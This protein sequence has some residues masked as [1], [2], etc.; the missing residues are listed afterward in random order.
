MNTHH[1][2]NSF[3]ILDYFND[4]V[5]IIT[6][7]GSI[8]YAN[9]TAYDRLGYSKEELLQKNIR[10][11][12]SPNY[13]RLIPER[14]EQFKQRDSLVFES[15][16]VTKDGSI[17]PV[18]VSIH[19]ILYNSTHCIISVV[20]DITSR[21]Q[22]EKELRESEEKWRAITE[23]LTDIVWIVNLQFETIYINK[24][25]E[26]LFGFTVDEYLQRKVQEKYPPEVLQDIY[27]KLIEE[28]ENEKKPGIDKNRTRIVEIQEYKKDGTLAD[29]SVHVKFLR[30]EAGNPNAIIGISR[31]ITEQKKRLKEIQRYKL[32]FEQSINEIYIFDAKTLMF[33]YVNQ[34]SINNLGYSLEELQRMTPVD[35]KP[36]FTLQQFNELLSPL[37]EG[38][39]KSIVFET[40]HK[41]KD[42][43]TYA[44]EVHLQLVTIDGEEHF[45][46]I[47]LD[48]SERKRIEKSL[49]ESEEKFRVLAKSTPMGIMLYQDDKWIYA[50][51]AAEALLKYSEQELCSMNF[52]DVV[53][54]D[55]KTFIIEKGR[56]RQKG[57]VV[58]LVTECRIIDKSGAIKWVLLHG[59]TVIYKGKPAGLISV[60]DVT[61]RKGMEEAL[62]ESEEKFRILAEST[63]MTIMMYQ[64]NKWIYANP[65]AEALLEYSE[66]ELFSMNFWDV[67]HPDDK[68]IVIERGSKRQKGEDA[69]VGY[70]FRVISKS[71]M[72][73]WVLLYGATVMYKGK[74]AGLI[75]VLDITER[76]KIEEEKR[77]LQE[78]L[79]QS[80]KMES[81]GTLAGGVA[82]EFNNMLNIISGHAELALLNIPQ[83]NDAR[84][85]IEEIKKAAERSAEIT[86]KLLKFARKQEEKSSIVNVNSAI[87]SM[88][89]MLK[90]LIG[91]NIQLVWQPANRELSVQI[92]EV[93][94]DQ[95]LV[96]LSVNARD[97]IDKQGTITIST[98]SVSIKDEVALQHN[99]LPGEYALI[100]VTDNGIGIDEETQK[101]IFDP[102]FTTK[103][104]GKGTGLGL[105]TV[106][107]IVK[108]N[109]GFI[110][111][112]SEKGKGTTFKIYLPVFI[113]RRKFAQYHDNAVNDLFH[114]TETILIVEDEVSILKMIKKMLEILGYTVLEAGDPFEALEIVKN[115]I[116]TIHL[117]ITDVVMPKMNGVDLAKLVSAIYPQI[118]I[119][120]TSGYSAEVLL[121]H[122]IKTSDINYLSKPVSFASLASTVR[123]ILDN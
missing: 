79:L 80:Q 70:E 60:M 25:V 109:G 33:T 100:Q 6:Y 39:E 2:E 11:I 102:F 62:K 42:G 44:V 22:A 63:P 91:E 55:D 115:Y 52:W 68:A 32:I 35:I 98:H 14:I 99:V 53:H 57:K 104:V 66:Q 72:I 46:A 3:D 74:P 71:G 95:I 26:K 8:V 10:D 89:G 111:V 15:E 50:N 34:A 77:K 37:R 69:T 93:S 108:N 30:D 61:D 5:F 51:P 48:I 85:D 88:I 1:F 103:E 27:N 9:K 81:I 16:Q 67:V 123:T 19:S 47:I 58:G 41:R 105:S 110:E 118:K 65:A 75:S 13:A 36:E 119:L 106:Y 86:K 18:E 114:G 116:G 54:P 92:D 120:Y 107:G 29:L 31:D 28:F 113:E 73:K 96:N 76:K 23:N 122:N 56:K 45:A 59:A 97:A 117:L 64:D 24:A 112:Q 21:K 90:R 7:D 40:V 94:I 43:S 49:D 12:D 17:I 87:D 84:K 78:Q 82:H 20:R 83:E 121:K 4:A 38:T 101:L